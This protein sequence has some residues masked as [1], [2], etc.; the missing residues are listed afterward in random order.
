M[1][2]LVVIYLFGNFINSSFLYKMHACLQLQKKSGTEQQGLSHSQSL[3]MNRRLE[4][5]TVTFLG[6]RI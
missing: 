6:T 4:P 2:K 3:F 1:G 5:S